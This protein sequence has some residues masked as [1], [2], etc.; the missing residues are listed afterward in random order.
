MG[1]TVSFLEAEINI[2]QKLA[3]NT[4]PGS[5]KTM[6]RPGLLERYQGVTQHVGMP[7]KGQAPEVWSR[8]QGTPRL[9]SA[10]KSIPLS[11]PSISP[12]ILRFT[13]CIRLKS[14][15]RGRT[16]P[17]QGVNWGGCSRVS[18]QSPSHP[19]RGS[20]PRPHSAPSYLFELSVNTA[21]AFKKIDDL[22]VELKLLLGIL[23]VADSQHGT[24]SR[25]E[26]E[27]ANL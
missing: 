5:P 15:T 3:A 11:L 22:Q 23:W 12:D 13:G 14:T 17:R 1:C 4:T 18:L 9:R 16:S 2:L 24:D 21:K 19:P 26:E 10:L 27:T 7:A 25:K 20:E 8:H 6:K